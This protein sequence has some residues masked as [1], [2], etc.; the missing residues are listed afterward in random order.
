M[1]LC[2]LQPSL[3]AYKHSEIIPWAQPTSAVGLW[4]HFEV[5]D[6]HLRT[7]FAAVTP[8]KQC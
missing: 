5:H 4:L 8:P 7:V 6:R 2:G 3:T 1:W